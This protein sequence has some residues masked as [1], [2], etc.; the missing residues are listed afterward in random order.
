MRCLEGAYVCMKLWWWGPLDR[1]SA[2]IKEKFWDVLNVVTKAKG[3]RWGGIRESN[4]LTAMGC[5]QQKMDGC[6]VLNICWSL[7]SNPRQWTTKCPCVHL[8][9][10]LS[11]LLTPTNPAASSTW[12]TSCPK[13]F[14]T[15]SYSTP[16]IYSQYWFS[17]NNILFYFPNFLLLKM[18]L[19]ACFF[20]TCTK[21]GM[22]QRSA[23]PL[24]DN[25]TNSR[26]ILYFHYH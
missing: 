10:E 19:G 11:G 15:L 16:L 20:N 9:H 25:D 3:W 6:T 4:Q 26:D 17:V 23:W 12:L 1:I 7:D 8:R 2:L 13:T 22:I 24:H 14:L 5:K 21:I 18:L